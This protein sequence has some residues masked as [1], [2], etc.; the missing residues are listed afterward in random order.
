MEAFNLSKFPGGRSDSGYKDGDDGDSVCVTSVY[1]R[2]VYNGYLIVVSY[3]NG[4]DIEH[5]A[6]NKTELFKTLMQVERFKLSQLEES[7]WEM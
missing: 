3:S 4:D 2:S 6:R 5:V 1:Y 7:T